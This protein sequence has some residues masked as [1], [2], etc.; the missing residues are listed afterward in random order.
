MTVRPPDAGSSLLGT[1]DS[2]VS[3][4]SSLEDGPR[5]KRALVGELECSRS[6][7]DRAIRELET[8]ALVERVDDA[9]RL[10]IVGR[11]ALEEYRRS[12]DRLEAIAGLGEYLGTV[13]QTV[14]LSPSVLEGATV[15]EP[16]PHAPHEPLAHLLERIDDADRFRGF[17]GTERIPQIRTRLYERTVEGS[18]TG[19]LVLADDLVTFLLERHPDQVR[20]VLDGGF[21]FYTVSSVPY[22]LVRLDTPSQSETVLV[23]TSDVGDVVV[24]NDS[25]AACE[26]G[27]AVYRR[28]RARAQR[29]E[30]PEDGVRDR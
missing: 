24:R 16:E 9:Y 19:E 30:P 2:R 1:I 29:L 13:P 10:T 15:H 28:Y 12:R 23:F 21:D 17:D 27:D 25:D 11:L 18:L 6:T 14:P 20:D 8:L 22:G 5:D 4:L 26:W 3:F 7:V